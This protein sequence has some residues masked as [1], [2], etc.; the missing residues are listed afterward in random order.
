MLDL[1]GLL[2]TGTRWRYLWLPELIN[3][4]ASIPSLISSGR[5]LTLT[6]AR[7]ASTARGVR[8]TGAATSNINAGAIH[9][10]SAKLWVSLRFRLDQTFDATATV[11]QFIW[12]KRIDAQNYLVAYL[13]QVDGKLYFEKFTAGGQ[14]FSIAAQDGAADIT[15]WTGQT[16]YHLI[17]SIS[18]VAAVRLRV[19]NGTVVTNADVSAAPAGGD[20]VV[21]DNDDPGAGTG[22]IGVIADVF[23]GTDDLVAAEEVDLYNGLPPDDTVN[24]WLLDEGRDTTANDRGSGANN[25]TLDSACTWDFDGRK[26]VA[27]SLDA[28]NDYL[29]ATLV[30]ISGSISLVWVFKAKSTYQNLTS[31]AGPMT[32]IWLYNLRVAA[33]NRLF[34]WYIPPNNGIRVYAIGAG[35]SI[36]SQ[37]YPTHSIDDYQVWIITYDT[38]GNLSAYVN[39]LAPVVTAT[40]GGLIS[41]AAATLEIGRESG[42]DRADISKTLFLGLTDGALTSVQARRLSRLLDR[43]MELGIGI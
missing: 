17:C 8:F 12:G 34:A 42:V 33:S 11:N 18:D 28:L 29:Q 7:K 23:V 41:A 3:G 37:F 31:P 6:G 36:F 27:A 4:N 13:N 22:F 16:W 10:A 15:S 1:K 39:G 26:L 20:F 38:S 19:N 25:G 14:D 43:Q 21:G 30:N 9:N 40:G 24:E 5:P 32:A 2:P 35:V